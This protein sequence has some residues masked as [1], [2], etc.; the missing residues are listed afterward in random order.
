MKISVVIATHNQKERLSLVLVGLREQIFGT[1]EFETIIVNDGCTDGTE[2]VLEYSELPNMQVI[3]LSPNQGRL[4]ARNIGIKKAQGK[5]VV[6]LDGDALPHPHLLSA[7]WQAHQHNSTAFFFGHYFSLPFVE[8]LQNPATG[9]RVARPLASFMRDYLEQHLEDW[10]VTPDMITSHFEAVQERAVE[11]IYPQQS[12]SALQ[13][14]VL[15]LFSERHSPVVGWL[16]FVPHNGAVPLKALQEVEGFDEVISFMEGWELAYR[17]QQSGYVPRPV[18]EASSYH[19]YHYH[20]FSDP[21]QVGAEVQ[22]RRDAIEYMASKH[23]LPWFRLIHFWLAGFGD[24]PLLPEVLEIPDLFVFD[25]CWKKMNHTRWLP[26]QAILD[27][28]PFWIISQEEE[29]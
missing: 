15:D 27:R 8:Y 3:T 20:R 6:F 28:H 17:L 11:G 4:K 12:V 13:R 5:L 10:L 9:K 26:Y 29:A 7:Y 25:E 19:L 23:G 14:Q 2:Q 1:D 22:I 21:K 18:L 16:G 24:L